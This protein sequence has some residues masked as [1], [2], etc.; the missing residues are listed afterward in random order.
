MRKNENLNGS[1]RHPSGHPAGC[2]AIQAFTLIELLV[3]IAIIAILAAMLLPALAKAKEKA[4]QTQCINNEKQLSL[5]AM[6]YAGDYHDAV[7]PVNW[8]N[9][10]D[11][12]GVSAPLPLDWYINLAA[13]FAGGANAVV[14]MSKV[15]NMYACPSSLNAQNTANQQDPPWNDGTGDDWPYMCDYGVNSYA[16]N[17]VKEQPELQGYL[18]KLSSVRHTSQT[19]WVQELVFQNNFCWWSFPINGSSSVLQYPNDQAAYQSGVADT[20]FSERHNGGGD[21]FWFDGHVSYMKYLSYISYAQTCAQTAA[22]TPGNDY[23]NAQNFL[24]GNW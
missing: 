23:P 19:P 22:P 24:I 4:K 16:N 7:V 11:P 18:T 17:M 2:R 3:V 10:W 9:T 12:T 14:S 20:Y 21:I 1:T 15:K 8:D 6:L 5:T 13:S